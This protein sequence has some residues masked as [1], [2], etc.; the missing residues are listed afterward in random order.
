MLMN[1]WD[2]FETLNTLQ[3]EVYATLNKNRKRNSS[4]A[5]SWYPAVD[6]HEDSQAYCFDVEA[7]GLSKDAFDISLDGNILTIKGERKREAEEKKEA[8]YFRVEREYGVFARSFSLPETADADNV[9][10]EY[11]NGILHIH[12]AKKELAKPR[13][14]PIKMSS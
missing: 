14:I 7:P 3:N 13:Q 10:A 6:I 5:A 8:N 11:K 4:E 2:P 12:V 9:S 1:H